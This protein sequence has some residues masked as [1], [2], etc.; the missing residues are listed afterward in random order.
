[1]AFVYL[2]IWSDGMVFIVMK[3]LWHLEKPS[4][5][6]ALAVVADNLIRNVFHE[7]CHVFREVT[8]LLPILPLLVE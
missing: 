8:P 2:V 1:M 4:V 7:M 5:G 3:P 6:A